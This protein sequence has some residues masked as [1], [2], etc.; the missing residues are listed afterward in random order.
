MLDVRR[1]V[2]MPKSRH[3]PRSKSAKDRPDNHHADIDGENLVGLT[4]N[5]SQSPTEASLRRH[6]EAPKKPT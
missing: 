5:Q 6:L 4:S 3:V 2:A 1:V